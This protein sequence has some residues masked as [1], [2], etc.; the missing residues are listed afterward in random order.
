MIAI[1]DKVGLLELG[2]ARDSV[3]RDTCSKNVESRWGRGRVRARATDW[4]TSGDPNSRNGVACY[5]NGGTLDAPRAQF[6][7]PACS[8]HSPA[9]LRARRAPQLHAVVVV[10]RPRLCAPEGAWQVLRAVCSTHGRDAAQDQTPRCARR[11]RPLRRSPHADAQHVACW[12]A[13]ACSLLARLA[14]APLG[15]PPA[16]WLSRSR[17]AGS[18]FAAL[19][20]LLDPRIG[21]FTL[22]HHRQRRS[23]PHTERMTSL[24]RCARA[25][26]RTR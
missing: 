22:G 12:C 6:G 3:T 4:S 18:L 13:T 19:F 25:P 24:M 26:S 17:Q 15:R 23:T 1:T 20:Y 5:H 9:L 2:E 7:W 21:L 8:G 16:G 10:Q 11:A 14:K